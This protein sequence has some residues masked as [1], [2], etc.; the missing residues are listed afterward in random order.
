M[1]LNV[2][3]PVFT[4]TVSEKSNEMEMHLRDNILF[5]NKSIILRKVTVNC[6]KSFQFSIS[7]VTALKF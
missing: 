3:S 6:C 2:P 5:Q 7:R 1:G 4:Q